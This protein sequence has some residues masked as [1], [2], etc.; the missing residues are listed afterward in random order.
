[1]C[2]YLYVCKC[3]YKICIYLFVCKYVHNISVYVHRCDE[4]AADLQA[5]RY[6]T[7]CCICINVNMY[8]CI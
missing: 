8:T 7:E 6:R 5:L 4:F 1:M 2:T 3:M